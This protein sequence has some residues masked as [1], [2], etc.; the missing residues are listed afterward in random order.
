VSFAVAGLDGG[1]AQPVEGSGEL[2][3]QAPALDGSGLG[4]PEPEGAVAGGRPVWRRRPQRPETPALVSGTASLRFQAPRLA[5]IGVVV[6]DEQLDVLL[7]ALDDA[8]LLL[9]GAFD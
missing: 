1:E 5:A 4:A 6:D 3:L 2:S 8:E 9:V 7:L